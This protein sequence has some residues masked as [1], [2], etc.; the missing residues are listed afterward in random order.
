MSTSLPELDRLPEPIVVRCALRPAQGDQI[1]GVHGSLRSLDLAGRDRL[2]SI[3]SLLRFMYAQGSI[4]TLGAGVENLWIAV[5]SPPGR[6]LLSSQWTGCPDVIGRH[7]G[8]GVVQRQ[9][10][11]ADGEH[12]GGGQLW[13]RL[14]SQGSSLP[15]ARSSRSASRMTP[16]SPQSARADSPRSQASRAASASSHQRR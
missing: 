15:R 12:A 13:R 5:E 14:D 1:Q 8:M 3:C 9:K 10:Y 2:A 7:G 11:S 16:D 4:S 6:G